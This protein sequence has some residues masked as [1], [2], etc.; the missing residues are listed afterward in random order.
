MV[1]HLRPPEN[2]EAERQL[3]GGI[4]RSPEAFDL[5]SP[6]VRAEYFAGPHHA[7][8]YRAME[9]LSHERVPIDLVT[10]HDRC[11][12]HR[13]LT[14]ATLAELW[15]S[16][17]TGANAEY[18]AKIVRHCGL[19]RK[20]IHAAQA[21]VNDAI[22]D[23]QPIDET[24]ADAERRIAGIGTAANGLSEPK[25][26]AQSMRE[27]SAR[28]DERAASGGRFAGLATGVE[29]LDGML[30]GLRAGEVVILGARPS[31]GKTALALNILANVSESGTAALFFSLEQPD[32]D[33]ADRLL[34]TRS[35]V[36]MGRI[37]RPVQLTEQ[38]SER[39]NS[40]AVSLSGC[41][42]YIDDTSDQ[43]AQRIGAVTSRA[44][45][46]HGVGLVVIDYLQ[47][48]RPENTKVNRTE[49]V[50][51]MALR[52]K[53]LARQCR[54]PIILLSQL[55]RESERQNNKPRLSD[56]RE[57]GD[58]EAHAD[59]VLLLHR[60]P[61]QHSDDATIVEV[62]VAKNRN[63]PTGEVTLKYVRPVLRFDTYRGW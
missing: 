26:I 36:A 25:A 34:A 52:V 58:I 29:D 46:R 1:E 22:A 5:V 21:I 8:V 3:L 24:L 15:E 31:V 56:L 43:T 38:E 45:N 33:I 50:G 9:T 59:R 10:V 12:M 27:A 18:H 37:V 39:I 49:Q 28:I 47:L 63:G 19:S 6:I 62:I 16:T 41:G 7:A 4:F 23:R 40:A 32:P 42:L 53:N 44:V 57:S 14:P 11:R 61:A 51:T 20:L 13:D 35:G 60:Q 30:G 55:N 17:P 54:V 2:L 48:M